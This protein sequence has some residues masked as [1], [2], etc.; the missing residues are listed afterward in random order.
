MTRPTNRDG[1]A[2]ARVSIRPSK[3]GLSDRRVGNCQPWSRGVLGGMFV[4][5]I[6]LLIGWTAL[7]NHAQ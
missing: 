1:L 7:L 5:L 6:M 4:F 2:E 3:R